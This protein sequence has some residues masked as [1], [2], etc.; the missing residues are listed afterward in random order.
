MLAAGNRFTAQAGSWSQSTFRL[1]PVFPLEAKI[2][3]SPAVSCVKTRHL[4]PKHYIEKHSSQIK[5]RKLSTRISFWIKPWRCCF[6]RQSSLSCR[7]FWWVELRGGACHSG[8]AGS[9]INSQN[10]FLQIE[11]WKHALLPEVGNIESYQANKSEIVPRGHSSSTGNILFYYLKQ[12]DK[13]VC[14]DWTQGVK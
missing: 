6:H 2:S 9:L 3:S 14:I 1:N 8:T 4:T 10:L 12:S 11:R 5:D 13:W 7:G